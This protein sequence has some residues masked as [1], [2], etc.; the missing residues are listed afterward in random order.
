MYFLGLSVK[1]SREEKNEQIVR[2]GV[3][4]QSHKKSHY[5]VLNCS[6]YFATGSS[7]YS[8]R[9]SATASIPTKFHA[10]SSNAQVYGM[11]YTESKQSPD[12]SYQQIKR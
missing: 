10:H 12:L 2:F 11:Y 1:A 6:S 3:Y 5:T 4:L 7:P 9:S 8:I